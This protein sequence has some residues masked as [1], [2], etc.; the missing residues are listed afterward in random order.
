M[1]RMLAY[2][3]TDHSFQQYKLDVEKEKEE[4]P[5]ELRPNRRHS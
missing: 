1:E 4:S 5:S 2:F 3:L